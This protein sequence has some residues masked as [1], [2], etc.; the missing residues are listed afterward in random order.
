MPTR[1]VAR[2]AT[3][4]LATV[5]LTAVTPA[6]A[7]AHEVSASRFDAP[8]P[9]SVLTVGAAVTV[10]ATALLFALTDTD[11]HTP[12]ATPIVTIDA[13]VARWVRRVAATAFFVAVVA[14]V[15][16]GLAGRQVAAENLATRFTWPVWVRG[17]ALVAVL[18]GSPWP[19]LSPWRTAYR[20]LCR[21]EGD[22][23]AVLDGYPPWLGAWPA[24][25]GFLVIV[26]VIQTLTVVPQSPSGT[27]AVIAVYA[28]AMLGGAV[29]VGPIWFERADPLE[30]LYRLLGCVA[31][32]TTVR[33]DAGAWRIT[34][35]PPWQD[36][37]TPT[38]GLA[39]AGVAVAAVYTVSFDGFTNTAPYRTLRFSTRRLV[40]T[41]QATS[42]LLYALGY[43]AFLGTFVG[44]VRLGDRLVALNRPTEPAATSDRDSLRGAVIAFAPTVLP[45]AAAYDLAHNYPS[46][47]RST[48][49][50]VD[51]TAARRGWTVVSVDPLAW[52]TVPAF[53]T[54]QVV[55]LVVGHVV[56][57]VAAH[58]VALDRYRSVSAVRRGHL[59]LVVL[60]ICYTVLSLWIISQPVIGG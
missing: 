6:V 30:V 59:P 19:T 51:S 40:G 42:I 47:I 2:L 21:L 57:V 24:L 46:V 17:L 48:A 38:A 20:A 52:L 7:G 14:A 45:I 31:S 58:R 35:R 26:G 9:L 41:G 28:L 50:L 29:L 13:R 1:R 11:P 32:V 49:R 33:T 15:G 43:V 25:A 16:A 12:E 18:V 22:R 3:V 5:T 27:S 44:T 54:T 37:T 23:I 56:A 8:I 4:A 36:C 53:W 55:L 60:M 10:A 39:V 34:V